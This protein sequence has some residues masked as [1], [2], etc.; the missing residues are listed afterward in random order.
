[1]NH[2]ANAGLRRGTMQIL[3]DVLY[4]NHPAV[5]LYKQAFELTKNM[6]ANQQCGIA[7]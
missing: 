1:M 7:L 2:R 6:P 4:R 5:Q 3:Q